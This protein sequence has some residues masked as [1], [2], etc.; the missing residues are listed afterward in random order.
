[1]RDKDPHR[2]T[3][4]C[5]LSE[6]EPLLSVLFRLDGD[7]QEGLVFDLRDGPRSISARMMA[8]LTRFP[9]SADIEAVANFDLQHCR[10]DTPALLCALLIGAAR[11]AVRAREGVAP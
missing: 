3:L 8:E 9:A 7:V 11:E 10:N 5:T 1:M 2:V 4:D 6:D